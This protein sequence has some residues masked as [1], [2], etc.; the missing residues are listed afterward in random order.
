MAIGQAELFDTGIK[1]APRA[2]ELR[3]ARLS[4]PGATK[5]V[6]QSGTQ[7]GDGGDS[8]PRLARV[9]LR[10]GRLSRGDPERPGGDGS[11]HIGAD[12][13]WSIDQATIAERRSNPRSVAQTIL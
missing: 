4:N 5:P 7:R 10:V 11:I 8:W 6:Y 12:P 3:A 2:A 13:A 1:L 9:G